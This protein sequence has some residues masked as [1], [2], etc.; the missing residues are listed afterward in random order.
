MR[1]SMNAAIMTAMKLPVISKMFVGL[2]SPVK[3]VTAKSMTASPK[4]VA[5]YTVSV[6]A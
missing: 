2:I 1:R 5:L 4:R 6:E 3:K